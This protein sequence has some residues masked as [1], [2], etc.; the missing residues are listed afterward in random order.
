MSTKTIK[1]F[2][3]KSIGDIYYSF[4]SKCDCFSCTAVGVQIKPVWTQ[5]GVGM[6]SRAVSSKDN[7]SFITGVLSSAGGRVAAFFEKGF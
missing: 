4:L 5:C 2:A 7:W 3:V 1:K 6:R